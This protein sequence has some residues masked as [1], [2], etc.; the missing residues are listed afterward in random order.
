M[1]SLQTNYF[2]KNI[3]LEHCKKISIKNLLKTVREHIK[4]EMM[5][6]EAEG[7]TLTQ[8]KTNYGGIRYWFSCPKCQRRVSV[9]YENPH[10][11]ALEC[12]ICTGFTYKKQKYKGMIEE[13][14]GYL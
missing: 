2:G 5:T 11:L 9:L 1:K 4:G 7:I 13:K 6:I 14:T 12:R 3:V 8:T 10:T